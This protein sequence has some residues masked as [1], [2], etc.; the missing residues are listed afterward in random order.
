M[1][2][3][4]SDPSRRGTQDRRGGVPGGGVDAPLT[5]TGLDPADGGHDL[6]GQAGTRR[7]RLVV[8]EENAGICDRAVALGPL[9]AMPAAAGVT[10]ATTSSGTP[11][12]TA[13][14]ATPEQG[15]GGERRLHATPDTS[16]VP[17][18][19]GVSVTVV[20]QGSSRGLTW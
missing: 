20:A 10:T 4:P 12:M 6:P 7:C 11:T 1:A 3:S 8:G 19:P 2:A 5:V 16:R 18:G 14:A 9:G 13:A 15:G 17:S